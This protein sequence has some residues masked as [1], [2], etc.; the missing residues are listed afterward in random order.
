MN[1]L[2]VLIPLA[3]MLLIWSRM[4]GALCLTMTR[5]HHRRTMTNIP[6]TEGM[7]VNEFNFGYISFIYRI[8]CR[9]VR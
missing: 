7:R 2:Y 4:A 1:M 9:F 3:V 5:N 8:F 6:K